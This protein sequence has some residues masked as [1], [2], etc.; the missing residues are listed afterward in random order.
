MALLKLA[1][2]FVLIVIALQRK[3]LVG[4]IFLCGSA[5][6]FVLFT[7]YDLAAELEVILS[8]K[9]ETDTSAL[10]L[11]I[12]YVY[13]LF[14][15]ITQSALAP[16]ALTLTTLVVLLLILSNSLQKCGNLQ[17]ILA[18]VRSNVKNHHLRI[19]LFP[20][21]IGLLPMPGGAIFSAPMVKELASSE[22]PPAQLSFFNY[23]F[24]HIWE[25]W[26]PLYPGI[27]LLTSLSN[28]PIAV[29]SLTSF[30]LMIPAV[31]FGMLYLPK[32]RSTLVVEKEE[33]EEENVQYSG[34]LMLLK[35]LTPILIAIIPGFL[36][37]GIFSFLFPNLVVSREIGLALAIIAANCFVW[38]TTPHGAS[39]IKEIIFN[40][41]NF[42]MGYTAITI[43]IFKGVLDHSGAVQQIAG[44]LDAWHISLFLVCIILPFITGLI[45]GIT[46][47]FV[48]TSFPIIISL[49]QTTLPETQILPYLILAL[50]SGFIGTLISPLHLCLILSNEYFQAKLSDVYRYLLP[51]CLGMLGCGI[52][53]FYILRYLL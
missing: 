12:S 51:P 44:E 15:T 14:S 5:V 2:V 36:L 32:K 8:G 17:R 18:C 29:Y 52:A 24:R 10:S 31:L 50:V 11:L 30:P 39:L 20:A 26:W 46:I 43:M 21:L 25:Y 41:H 40:K 47:G 42:T 1:L 6:L 38:F 16:H 4:H 53:Y 23:W 48:G 22:C 7:G 3:I 9:G 27:L 49:L 34:L 35:E 13:N 37:G 33:R 28:T 19:T 45:T